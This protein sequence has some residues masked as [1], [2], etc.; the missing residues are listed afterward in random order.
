MICWQCTLLQ[1][2]IGGLSSDYELTKRG[3][4]VVVLEAPGKAGRR[5]N[6]AGAYA[7]NSNWG[8]EAAK[9]SATHIA[10]AIVAA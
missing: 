7:D 3:H 6:F 1:I 4:E 2:G 10:K 9:R 5:V 8:Q